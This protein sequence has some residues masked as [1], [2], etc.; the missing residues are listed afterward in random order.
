MD[1]NGI[2]IFISKDLKSEFGVFC[3]NNFSSRALVELQAMIPC[4]R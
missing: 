2:P 1:V 4:P 3:V